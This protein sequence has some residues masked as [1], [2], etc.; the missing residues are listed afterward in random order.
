MKII[1]ENYDDLVIKHEL[2]KEQ[3]LINLSHIESLKKEKHILFTKY[4][5]NN[6]LIQ[7]MNAEI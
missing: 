4:N 7:Q 3:L 1:E 5:E 2:V 6:I